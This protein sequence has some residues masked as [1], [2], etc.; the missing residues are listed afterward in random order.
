MM[1]KG[2]VWLLVP[3]VKGY[4]SLAFHRIDNE[5]IDLSDIIGCISDKERAFFESEKTFEF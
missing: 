5:V 2:F 1:S 3:W 4:E